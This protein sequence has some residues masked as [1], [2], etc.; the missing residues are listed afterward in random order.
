MPRGDPSGTIKR[1]KDEILSAMAY[2]GPC[3]LTQK[4]KEKSMA[5]GFGTNTNKGDKPLILPCIL[6]KRAFISS[7]TNSPGTMQYVR[8]ELV[9]L[10]T[11][12]HSAL[13]LFIYSLKSLS[14]TKHLCYILNNPSWIIFKARVLSLGCNNSWFSSFLGCVKIWTL[15]MVQ[16]KAKALVIWNWGMVW[17]IRGAFGGCVLKLHNK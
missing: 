8:S 3:V 9:L 7:S 2:C 5:F 16:G 6:L 15:K 10:R 1:G 17:Y 13:P 12:T 4:G 11:H 14:H